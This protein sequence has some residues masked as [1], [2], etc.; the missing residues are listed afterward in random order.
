MRIECNSVEDFM[1][2]LRQGH[3][4]FQ[5][6]VFINKS[7]V[8]MTGDPPRL[9]TSVLVNIQLSAAMLYD[10]GADALIEC[11]ECCGVDRRT[12]DGELNGTATFEQLETTVCE[13]AEKHNWKV[14]P[15]ILGV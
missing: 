12:A 10:G 5:D 9:A 15:G 2:N 3:K 7:V 11:G 14:L 1:E 13:F 8:S 4:V 6:T